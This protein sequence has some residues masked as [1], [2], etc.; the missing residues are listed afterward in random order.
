ME[1]FQFLLCDSI[2]VYVRDDSKLCFYV[3]DEC[4]NYLVKQ[5]ENITI[6]VVLL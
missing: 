1:R 3:L 6:W 5:I 2:L 4:H